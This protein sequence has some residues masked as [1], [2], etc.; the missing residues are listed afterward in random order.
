MGSVCFIL[1]GMRLKDVSKDI[2]A[3]AGKKVVVAERFSDA[4]RAM[5]DLE[6]PVVVYEC[7]NSVPDLQALA[8]T[9]RTLCTPY[10]PWVLE[11][12]DVATRHVA[13][14]HEHVTQ[15]YPLL[16]PTRTEE[17]EVFW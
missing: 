13:K 17:L 7:W 8:R 2:V 11:A 16:S 12:Q 15:V 10:H 3:S 1:V 6:A 5:E 4:V 9:V 14:H